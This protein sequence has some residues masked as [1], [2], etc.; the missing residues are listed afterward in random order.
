MLGFLSRQCEGKGL[1]LLV[2]AFLALRRT[3]GLERL[4]LRLI[5]G[6]TPQDR[7]FLR[8]L[9]RRIAAAGAAA[10]VEWHPNCP[11][12]ERIPLLRSMTVLS[13]PQRWR[14]ASGIFVLE[15]LACGVPVVLPR[16]GV[17]PELLDLTGGGTL[18]EPGSAPDLSRALE[19]LLAAPD[20]ARELGR[21]GAEA[22]RRRFSVEAMAGEFVRVCEG[23]RP[24]AAAAAPARPAGAP[25]TAP[26]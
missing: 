5:G 21:H 9:R 25:G 24:G 26:E 1:D 16:H 20:R 23:L 18:F 10:D 14:E 15:A 22:V 4:R 2:D 11:R 7:R 17:F 12:E 6:H 19:S 13:V 8:A 3:R